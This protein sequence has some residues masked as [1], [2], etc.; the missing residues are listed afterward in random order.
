MIDLYLL[1]KSY[2]SFIMRAT[3]T[4]PGNATTSFQAFISDLVIILS[5]HLPTKHGLISIIYLRCSDT[6]I[7]EKSL[8]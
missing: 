6:S 7:Y 8:C 3:N 1:S 5:G 2:I 4:L